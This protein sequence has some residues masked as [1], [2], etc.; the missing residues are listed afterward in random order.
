MRDAENKPQPDGEER[1]EV[2]AGRG[3]NRY[4]RRDKFSTVDTMSS[5][6]PKN[7]NDKVPSLQRFKESKQDLKKE[8]EKKKIL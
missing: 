1:E 5:P 7:K 2:A 8:L 4:R 6:T 3:R